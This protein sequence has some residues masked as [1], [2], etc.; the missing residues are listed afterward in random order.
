MV[1][2]GDRVVFSSCLGVLL[3][4]FIVH[5]FVVNSAVLLCGFK[6]TKGKRYENPNNPNCIA[7]GISGGVCVNHLWPVV[8]GGGGM[9]DEAPVQE[10]WKYRRWNDGAEKWELTDDCGW[11]SEPVYTTPPAAPVQYQRREIGEGDFVNCTKEQ[12]EYAEGSPQMDTRVILT[13]PAAQP[14]PVQHVESWEDLHNALQRIDTAAVGLPT[15]QV[16]HEG[17]L[18]AVVQNIVDAI[19]ALHEDCTT[20]PAA[21]PAPV[22]EPVGYEHHEYRPY[23]APGEIR[24]HAILKSRYTMPDGSTAGDYQWLIDQHRANKN[25]IKLIPLY[26]TPPAAQPAPV[27]LTNGHVALIAAWLETQMIETPTTG[28]QLANALRYVGAQ[29]ITE[30]GQP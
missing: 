30:K 28:P 7:A 8:A 4:F 20:P 19:V 22:Q 14:A 27:P 2:F 5:G 24:I 29:G 11:P 13:P 15:F 25:T 21:Q 12:Y 16:R 6:Q 18:D 17:G 9:K 23:G 10:P 26:T 1:S 3:I